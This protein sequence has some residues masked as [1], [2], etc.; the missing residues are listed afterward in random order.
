MLNQ[1]GAG[2]SGQK[3]IGGL[4]RCPGSGLGPPACPVVA[5]GDPPPP[6]ISF[7]IGNLVLYPKAELIVHCSL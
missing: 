3:D 7:H 6:M 4:L 2:L 1:S 5:V